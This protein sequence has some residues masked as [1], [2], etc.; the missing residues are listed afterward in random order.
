MFRSALHAIAAALFLSLALPHSVCGQSPIQ[1][2]GNARTAIDHARQ[3]SL[4]LMFWITDWTSYGTT[5]GDEL[6]NEQEEAFCDPR[7]V[8]IAKHC[9]VAVRVARN[10]RVI[11][12]CKELGL[13]TNFGN[14]IALVSPDGKLLGQ[15][16]QSDV[17]TPDVMVKRLAETY[18]KYCD[19]LYTATLKPII[20]N[21]ESKKDAVRTAV[22]TVWRLKIT[23]ADTDWIA[24]MDRPDVT[25]YERAKLYTLLASMPT[26]AGITSL[27]DRAAKG[28]RDA[29]RALENA[30]APALE[31]LLPDMPSQDGPPPTERQ[32]I[33]YTA[34]ARICGAVARADS[35]WKTAKPADRAFELNAVKQ[36][37]EG[38]LEYWK[39]RE[40]GGR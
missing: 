16:V 7:I 5:R 36:R 38:A 34:A 26:K 33:A 9:Y 14:Y 27:L 31:L 18:A 40:G 25:Q 24:L 22:Q 39:R 4:P 17:A 30:E 13:P 37:A 29:A 20:T 2:G 28:D 32:M 8:S 35:F 10:S 19:D 15:I 11:E 21:P 3:Q 12:E 23:S 1:W 6:E